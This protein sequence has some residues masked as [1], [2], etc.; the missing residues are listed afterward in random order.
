MNA[1]LA[2]LAPLAA[3]LP[4]VTL[5]ERAWMEGV[6]APP[7]ALLTALLPTLIGMVAFASRGQLGLAVF[8]AA[9]N[10]RAGR[11]VMERRAAGSAALPSFRRIHALGRETRW[12]IGGFVVVWLVDGLWERVG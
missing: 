6:S 4:S 3:F 12:W 5:V 8:F 11:L 9:W 2:V 1:V 7:K 10:L